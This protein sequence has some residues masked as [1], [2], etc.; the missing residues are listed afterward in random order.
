MNKLSIWQIVE[1]YQQAASPQEQ[2]DLLYQIGIGL[3]IFTPREV[4]QIAEQCGR[5]TEEHKQQVLGYI[6]VYFNL[7][8]DE[9]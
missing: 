2:N 4:T 5:L 1:R 9:I 6:A 3:Q 7:N 8:L